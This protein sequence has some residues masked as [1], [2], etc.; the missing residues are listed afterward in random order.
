MNCDVDRLVLALLLMAVAELFFTVY[1]RVSNTANLLGHI[2]KVFAYY[3]LYRAIYSETVRRP[4]IQIAEMLVSDAVTGLPNRR[5]LNQRLEQALESVGF[6]NKKLALLLLNLD[7]FHSVNAIFGHDVGDMLLINVAKRI[8][9][10]LPENAY[11][12]RFSN[13]EFCILIENTDAAQAEQLGRTVQDKL[14]EGFLLG[15]DHVETGASV[16]LVLY[17]EDGRTSSVLLSRAN[18]ALHHAKQHGRNG[19][20]VFSSDLAQ[21]LERK[22]LL[23][24]GLKKA[25]ERQ[26]FS[27]HYQPKVDLGNG[28]ITGA[29]ALLR[30]ESDELGT[31][32]PMEFIPIAEE[33]GLILA[34]GDWVMQEAC[35]QIGRWYDKGLPLTGLAVNVSTRQFRQKD[36]VE[37]VKRVLQVTHV[38]AGLLEL[39]LTESAIMDNVQSAALML[40]ELSSMGIRIAIDDFGTGYSSL[41][42]LKNFALHALKIDRSF[43]RDIPGDADDEMLVRMIITL[44]SNLGLL[45]IAEGV[46][47]SAQLSYLKTSQCDQLQGYYFSR[48]LT[49]SA[50]EEMLRADRRLLHEIRREVN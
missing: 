35:Q 11:V 10:S 47:T 40:R 36:F 4:F 1:V 13:D 6:S 44:A 50:F 7:H 38:P 3:Y 31:I 15:K 12:A 34:I 41:G 17:P 46:E 37:K 21:Q 42:Y 33:S 25:L 5:G 30:W 23:E 14:G 19:F 16:G 8:Q 24:N 2:Y 18:M 29:E 32:S 43:I 26:E 48:P 49:A 27:L 22:V 39:E 28:K 20:A 9:C 45:V